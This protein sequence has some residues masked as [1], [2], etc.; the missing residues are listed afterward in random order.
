MM[1]EESNSTLDFG[2]KAPKA[3]GN[4]NLADWIKQLK[5]LRSY[6]IDTGSKVQHGEYGQ[7]YHDG[8]VWCQVGTGIVGGSLHKLYDCLT[9]MLYTR[10][11]YRKMLT[12][13]CN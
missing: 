9:P 5:A 7:Q 8:C 2:L 6:R 13:N 3:S 4:G 12:V 10:N 11:K 1:L